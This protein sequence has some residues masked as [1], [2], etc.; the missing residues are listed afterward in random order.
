MLRKSL[1]LSLAF[2]IFRRTQKPRRKT[3]KLTMMNL[4]IWRMK[5]TR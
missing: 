4:R 5:M 2:V 1:H 3:V